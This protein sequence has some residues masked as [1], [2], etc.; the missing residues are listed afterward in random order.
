MPISALSALGLALASKGS[1]RS[2]RVVS[3][4]LICPRRPRHFVLEEP[5]VRRPRDTAAEEDRVRDLVRLLVGE[6]LALRRLDEQ[7]VNPAITVDVKG[8]GGEASQRKVPRNWLPFRGP[9]FGQQLGSIDDAQPSEV[10]A[11][12]VEFE[13]SVVL[14]GG[15]EPSR[16]LEAARVLVH[17]IARVLVA[18]PGGDE[19]HRVRR[20]VVPRNGA[21]VVNA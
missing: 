19:E 9:R 18:W 17:V 5:V 1:K 15:V 3:E 11:N 14:R 7:L 2:V 10:L 13:E 8:N 20:S 21:V 4:S 6:M 16:V 12:P